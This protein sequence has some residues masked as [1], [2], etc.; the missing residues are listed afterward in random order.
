IEIPDRQRAVLHRCARRRVGDSELSTALIR[1][2]PRRAL[3]VEQRHLVPLER[4]LDLA[5]VA[6]GPGEPLIAIANVIGLNIQLISPG[7]LREPEE[8]DRPA[9]AQVAISLEARLV[10]IRVVR[11]ASKREIDLV[12]ESEFGNR[13]SSRGL[14]DVPLP[15]APDRAL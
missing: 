9:V 2:Q 3:A 10:G 11:R 15:R 14:W 6:V 12:D 13:R 1:V 5:E 4:G 8:I 7:L